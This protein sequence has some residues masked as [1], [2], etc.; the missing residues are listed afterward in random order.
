MIDRVLAI[1][2]SGDAR[3]ARRK[4]WLCEVAAGRVRRLERGRSRQEVAE[5]LVAEARRDPRL[6]V[7]LDFAFSFPAGFLRKR[8]HRRV[9]TVWDEAAALGEQWLAH[10]PAPFW[11]KPG[12]RRPALGD[13]LYRATD[14]RVARETGLRP[15]SVFQVGGAGSV[16]TGSV[17]GMPVLAQLRAAG[18]AIWPFDEPRPPLVVEIWPR[19]FVG[20]LRKSRREER[21]RHL[22]AQ[23]PALAVRVRRSAERSDDAFDALL[24]GL[25]IDRH[26]AE[27]RRL[28]PATDPVTRLEGEIW[29]PAAGSRPE[30][31][32]ETKR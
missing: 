29:R 1:D 12:K 15:L 32:T 18:F 2:W 23:H 6:A 5:H 27:L 14:L 28:A 24:A 16:G 9:E 26:R 7:G 17:R 8:A 30:A 13:A 11:G 19:L 22:A 20:K 25:A 21:R 31:E 10:C 4:I 3:N